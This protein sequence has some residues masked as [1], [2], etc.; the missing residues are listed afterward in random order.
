MFGPLNAVRAFCSDLA[1]FSRATEEMTRSRS[2]LARNCASFVCRCGTWS[3]AR[4]VRLIA[5]VMP[6]MSGKTGAMKMLNRNTLT[7]MTESNP[8]TVLILLI[9][10]QRFREGSKKTAYSDIVQV[11]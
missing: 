11:L 8:R 9:H 7:T 2:L 5:L 10:H 3:A 1:F 6:G 4:S